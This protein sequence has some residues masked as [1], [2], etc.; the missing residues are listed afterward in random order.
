MTISY[1]IVET[2][3]FGNT[4]QSISK[5]IDGVVVMS[6]PPINDNTYYQEYLAWLAEG[7]TPEPCGPPPPPPTT[8]E[9]IDRLLTDYDLTRDELRAALY[10]TQEV[11]ES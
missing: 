10:S 2:E 4:S 1:Q 3:Y 8:A 5:L 9:K 11:P 7:N 6:I